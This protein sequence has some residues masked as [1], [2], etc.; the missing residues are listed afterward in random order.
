MKDWLRRYW[1]ILSRPSVHFSL[2]FLT[3][4]GFIAGILFWGGFNTAM[5]VTNTEQFCT[6][7]HE[8]EANPF[9]ELRGT[10]HYDNRS[11]VRATCSDCHVPH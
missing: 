6:S 10:I 3:L 1:Q 9:Q 7:C 8:M 5:E 11:G 4:G 2:G